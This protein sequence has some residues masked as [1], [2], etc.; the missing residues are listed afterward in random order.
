MRRWEKSAVIFSL[1]FS[2]SQLLWSYVHSQDYFGYNAYP[3]AM[4][5]GGPF[6]SPYG[7]GSFGGSPYGGSFYD[8][9]FPYYRPEKR[10]FGQPNGYANS[11][12]SFDQE[13]TMDERISAKMN[14]LPY[15]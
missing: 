3:A 10:S 15:L 11:H 12:D 6:G 4:L 2:C 5:G 14:P 7:G 13:K 1:L 9:Q 8:D